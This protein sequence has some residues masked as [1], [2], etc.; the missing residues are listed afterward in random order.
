MRRLIGL[1]LA[2]SLAAPAALADTDVKFTL[3]WK[4]EGPAAPFFIA[5]D[6][7]YFAEEGV[8]VTIDSGAGS[9][10]SIPRVA[11][12]AYQMGFGDINALIKLIDE[13]PDLKV[14]AVMMAYERPPIAII[15]RV[16]Q[17]VSD[18]PKSLEGKTLGA[19]P[20]DAAY[21]QWP[22]SRRSRGSIPPRSPLRTSAF[23]CA[24]PCWP[25]GRSM[26]FSATRFPRS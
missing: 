25:R 26:R 24:S 13:Q 2:A 22:P 8:N 14:K 5:L 12:G 18:D 19:P 3:D 7:G 16:S 21:G 11:T 23:R 15:G 4:F 17:G 10:E 9:R 20:P 1:A 6:K